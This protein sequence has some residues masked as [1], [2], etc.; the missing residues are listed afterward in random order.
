MC[1]GRIDPVDVEQEKCLA[2]MVYGEARGESEAGKVA[3]AYTALNRTAKKTLCQVVL[4]PKQYS[5][6]NNNPALRTAALSL[7][8][9]PAQKNIIDQNSWQ[10]S[11]EVAAAVVRG[12]VPDPTNGS[13]HYLAPKVMAS[14]GYKYPR[15][16]KEYTL[17][18]VVDNHK[19]YKP[20]DKP[21]TKM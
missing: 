16:S 21:A 11:M 10:K 6:F 12:Y 17:V 8:V 1:Y 19:F 5:I 3:V 13:T 2:V 14:K 20:V 18:A 15:W 7:H 9:E 4:A